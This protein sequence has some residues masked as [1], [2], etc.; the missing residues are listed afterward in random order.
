MARILVI[1]SSVAHGHVGLSAAAPIL[2]AL[3]HEVIGLPTVLLSNH[4]GWSHTAGMQVDPDTLRQMLEALE[5]N[6]WLGA[7]DA[8][9]TGYLPTPA[10]V[11]LAVDA[12]A[13]VKGKGA[14]IVV[15]P[16]LGD[17]PK[18]LYIAEEAAHALRDHLVPK[19]DILTPNA[20]E[21]SWLTGHPT[22]DIRH[23]RVAAD[24]F[25]PRVLV[26]SAPVSAEDTG[27]LD[28]GSLY[29]VP[30]RAGV[31]HGVGDVF[32]ALIAGGVE[33]DQAVGMLQT[34]IEGSLGAD[35]LRIAQTDWASAGPVGPH[36]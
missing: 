23:T 17:A 16:V 27:V 5:A 31:P 13:R 29:E 34:L 20:F 1:S 36:K 15:D 10:H 26:T 21:L 2:Q 32:A 24:R 3:G 4:P 22:D 30:L 19:A 25:A 8:C 7:V 6:G 12:V 14:R 35:H 28:G 9:L 18:G 11:D 33:V